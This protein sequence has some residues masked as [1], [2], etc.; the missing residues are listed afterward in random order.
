MPKPVTAEDVLSILTA[1][2]PRMS[3]EGCRIAFVVK[4]ADVKKN[5]YFT[6]LWLSGNK[7]RSARPFTTGDQ[8]DS[9]PRWSPDGTSILFVSDRID[10]ISQIYLIRTSGGEAER[11][12]DLPP[13]GIGDLE[14]SPDGKQASFTFQPADERDTK[15]AAEKRKKESKS[16]PPRE[17][18]ALR[19]REEGSGFLPS[20]KPHIWIL[21]VATGKTKQITQSV[22]GESGAIWS[23]DGKSLAYV[24]NRTPDP[25]IT[26]GYDDTFIIPA[27]GG[28]EKRVG[29][30]AGHAGSLA[31]SPDG[32]RIAYFGDDQPDDSWGSRDL[33]LWSVSVEGGDAVCHTAALDRPVGDLT[34]ADIHSF[35]AGYAGPIWRDNNLLFLASEHG[36]ARLHEVDTATNAIETVV[37]G[38]C[39]VMAV[40]ADATGDNVAM[41][42]GS[43]ASPAEVYIRRQDAAPVRVSALNDR[44]VGRV[45]VRSPE[46]FWADNRE[47][48]KTNG[49]IIRP[50]GFD[51]TT[52]YPMILEIHG[53]P[54][55]QYGHS[56]FHEA[57]YLAAQ[58]FVVVFT[59]PRGSKGYGEDWL[60]A[61]HGR[62]GDPD[63]VD[64]M[65]VVDYVLSLGYVDE[66]RMAVT[67][68]S[69]GGFMTAWV[70]GH[71]G[72]FA[73][74]I[75]D[76]GVYSLVSFGGTCDF[77]MDAGYFGGNQW[78]WAE[79]LLQHSPITY[80]P[81]VTTP[82]MIL[83]S[84][85]D[86]RCPIEQ[87][88]QYFAALRKM[89]KKVKYLRFPGECNHGLSRGG[90]PD[91]R[92]ARLKANLAWFKEWLKP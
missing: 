55:S 42:I 28:E 26:P 44:L 3:P 52:K 34:L 59:N 22:N 58:G 48:G 19:F 65:G 83:H 74:A 67:G 31:W 46:E 49:W 30:P 61:L 1:L 29:R 21:D 86:L 90:P 43:H 2:D 12:T 4:R 50:P 8:H 62:W 6:N 18:T 32:K 10:E 25:D 73:C 60:H 47:G 66:K 76:R 5:K 7:T 80:A 45:D 91:L 51:P 23:P 63:L 17:I 84:E 77:P 40:S 82:L 38:D 72:R 56:F 16:T 68:G 79:S 70:V 89:G 88:D 57:Q 64:L 24:A 20:V 85:G 15:A 9:D 39:A 35:G 75:S 92:I 11:L 71:T 41:I 14:W 13:G 33:K 27:T 87:A 78:E 37:G 54:H 81:N 53:G 69:Y 36:R